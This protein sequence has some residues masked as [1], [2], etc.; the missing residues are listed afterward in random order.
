SGQSADD[1]V[2]A[3]ETEIFAIAEQG[4]RAS[5]GPVGLNTLLTQAVNRIEKLVAHEG[6]LSGL[7]TGLNEF[8]KMTNG[9]QPSDLLILAGRPSMGK[10]SLAMNIVENVAIK[11]KVP[12]AVFSLEMSSEQLV[13]RMISSWGR[14]DQ[15]RLRSGRLTE[16]D[17]PKI[18]SAI[19]IMNENAHLF[20]D[21]T[22]GLSPSEMRARAR[23]L[24]REHDIGLIVV[25]YLQLMSVPG[26][27]ENRT[28][29][30]S[31]ISRQLKAMAKEL[32]VPV[33]ALSQLNR[34]VESRD[35]K[36]PRMSDLRESGGI[37]QDADLIIF[38]YRD[39]VYN[40]TNDDKG[41]AAVVIGKQRNGPLGTA[42]VAF[43]GHLTRFE[44][45]QEGYDDFID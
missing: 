22:P 39:E 17:W 14:V 42:R 35:N 8:D 37:E 38:V 3:A 32:D 2:G 44:N 28:N 15:S 20:I 1:I 43:L 4:R 34:Q 5:A 13:L 24:K 36:R 7:P 12:V 9:M 45:L 19:G 41:V 31:E 6:A 18:T 10:T 23:R 30:I 29:E 40:E 21:D 27:R 11:E 33:I 25:D 16:E 26:T